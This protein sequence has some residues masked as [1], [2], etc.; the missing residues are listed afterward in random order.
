[1]MN[2]PSHKA[3]LYFLEVLM[4]SDSPITVDQLAARFSH[5]S[6]SL[7]MREACGGG[8]AEGL[9]EFLQRYPSLFN[10]KPNGQVTSVAIELPGLDSNFDSLSDQ[11]SCSLKE[12][13]QKSMSDNLS[14]IS[15]SF[16]NLTPVAVNSA[17]SSKTC[18]SG[19]N[20]QKENAYNRFPPY[21]KLNSISTDTSSNTHHQN[22]T[23]NTTSR[24][25]STSSLSLV[26]SQSGSPLN[27]PSSDHIFGRKKPSN[28]FVNSNNNTTN[29]SNG[30][31]NPSPHSLSSGNPP[32][33][34]TK[35]SNIYTP[36]QLRN[37]DQSSQLIIPSNCEL[38][39]SNPAATT[40]RNSSNHPTN[41]HEITTV[42]SG[43]C[44]HCP[45]LELACHHTHHCT[46]A[47]HHT[48]THC[49][50]TPTALTPT[51]SSFHHYHHPL[52]HIP[53]QA[54][55][56]SPPVLLPNF[57]SLPPMEKL[58]LESE[59]VHF[60]QQ[61]LIKREERWVPIKSL[62]GHLSQATP[63]V[64][65]I[66]GPQLEFRR[67]L[68][69]HPHVF[70]VQGELVSV[71]EPFLTTGL[72]GLPLKR[73]RDRLSAVH[74]SHSSTNISNSPA[75]VSRNMSY[76]KN[77]R[78]KSLILPNMMTFGHL[79]DV[80]NSY[81]PSSIQRSTNSSNHYRRSAHFAVDNSS[82]A[83]PS[84]RSLIQSDNINSAPTTP[85]TANLVFA[86][87]NHSQVDKVANEK[88]ASN[89]VPRLHHNHHNGVTSS[90]M[91]TEYDTSV[92]TNS[93]PSTT[94][95]SLSLTMTANEYRA[96]M[97]LRK[98]LE[99]QGGAVGQSGLSLHNLMQFLS[100][101]APEAV[102][103]TI[104]WT[105][106]ELE[107]F[108]ISADNDEKT[109]AVDSA[110]TE[111]QK[112]TVNSV[113]ID[114]NIAVCNRR[115]NRMINIIITASKSS[116][117]NGVRTLTNRCGR[118]FHVAKLW[119]IIDLGKHEHVFFDKSIFRHVDDL[120]KHFKVSKL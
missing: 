4:N 86:D 42:A 11:E 59:A 53:A 3:M 16:R 94:V 14:D 9:K 63:E 8:S 65:A 33:G 100:T 87:S 72:G 62:A 102:Q 45:L 7:E 71:K 105:K 60:F 46:T 47:H 91:T 117:A 113:K 58:F 6:F 112:Q 110:N 34:R 41:H 25:N 77:P 23:N 88:S 111:K 26:S 1:M 69:K 79:A 50:C 89:P 95:N 35:P 90:T 52:H 56:R 18:P 55:L 54:S 28:N 84:A 107:E 15:T 64:R 115:L 39:S 21:R 30:T 57:Y 70:E 17:Y 40:N 120:Q 104:G 103:T 68:L 118:I 114:D 31:S 85:T 82:T 75:Y 73:S 66:V 44:I 98:V 119:G 22:S 37:L 106:I 27:T 20:L 36:P 80:N 101:K 76:E 93:L 5:K 43:T 19:N 24:L 99:K 38:C 96:I 51:A 92:M 32:A 81:V 97:F 48:S 10:V 109:P 61:K 49:H 2:D 108:L 67:F 74:A 83:T 13:G 116:D 12:N 29:T 78:P